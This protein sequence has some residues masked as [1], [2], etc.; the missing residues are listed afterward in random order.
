MKR[1]IENY[2][3]NAA[4]KQIV[5]I[6]DE[7]I[8][9]EKLLL[10]TNMTDG[11]I[12]FNFADSASKGSIVGNIITL[13]YDT[14]SMNNTDK[15]QI[16]VEDTNPII[17]TICSVLNIIKHAVGRI[18]FDTLNQLRA[19]VSGTVAISSGTINTVGAMT[20]GN[21]GIGDMGKPATSILVASQVANTS[22]SRNFIR[23]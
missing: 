21:I 8:T 9:Q 1:L 22:I 17:V 18:T 23:S 7:N 13:T 11:I 12:I 2:T 3:F 20:T 19:V 15:L 14:V 16:W 6:D 4:T 5:I 10:I